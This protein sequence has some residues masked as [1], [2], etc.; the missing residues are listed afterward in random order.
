MDTEFPRL[1]DRCRPENFPALPNTERLQ[2]RF[3]EPDDPPT[4]TVAAPAETMNGRITRLEILF[5]LGNSGLVH[6][7]ANLYRG[8]KCEQI[9]NTATGEELAAFVLL[10]ATRAGML[11]DL[12]LK[13]RAGWLRRLW[14]R[15]KGSA[16]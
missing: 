11:V 3:R 1:S 7:R 13:P 2:D 9:Q 14:R 4:S 12:K 16:R 6:G 8:R 5:R 15:V 10:N